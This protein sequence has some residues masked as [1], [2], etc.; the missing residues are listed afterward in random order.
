MAFSR[1][2]MVAA[3]A[4]SI[5]LALL[6]GCPTPPPT[7]SPS[8]NPSV[9]P[10]GTTSTAPS[11]T[12][13]SSTAPST[14]PSDSA[15]PSTTPSASNL[16]PTTVRGSVFDEDGARVNTA[17]VRVRS[18]NPSNPFDSTVDVN[19]GNYV[20][21][22]VPA[23]VAVELTVSREGWTSR[24]RVQTLLPLENNT[25]DSNL[26][27]FGGPA[28]DKD[29]EG[30]A[31]F[32]SD[33]P[34]V[35]MVEPADDADNVNAST[36]SV[37]LTLSEALDSTNQRRFADAIRVF[38]GEAAADPNTT[39]A[40]YLSEA[41]QAT[42]IADAAFDDTANTLAVTEDS[43]FLGDDDTQADVTWDT[44]G[45]VATLTFNAPLLS[46]D[47]ENLDYVVALV[48]GAN[49]VE[50]KSGNELGTDETGVLGT[51]NGTGRLIHFA[52]REPSLA[53]PSGSNTPGDD[54]TRWRLTHEN[55]STFSVAEDETEPSLVSVAVSQLTGRTRIS[56]T[57]SEPMAAYGGGDLGIYGNLN[58]AGTPSVNNTNLGGGDVADFQTR[59][60][61]AVAETAADLEDVDLDGEGATAQALNVIGDTDGEQETELAFNFGTPGTATASLAVNPDDPKTLRLEIAK[62]NLF[63]ADMNAIKVR[64]EGI[65]DPAGNTIT[66][67]QADRNQKVGNI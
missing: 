10:S 3:V 16:K 54:D 36:V 27:N 23:G 51:S 56:L 11:T 65:S 19:G 24:T 29:G 45:T 35:S 49:A 40:T 18:L 31:Y 50:D 43:T 55:F 64:V 32:I 52:F 5:S 7:V 47:N 62:A 30:P 60:T 33:F 25:S 8:G 12:P 38:P 53:V 57:F 6:T 15:S 44:T 58:A 4:G 28:S 67:S 21:N 61:F 22:E 39:N 63:D 34:E 9:Q 13:T 59:L 42:F 20:V 48:A 37:K 66:E 17:K 41:Q 46:D 1:N 26:V 14:N 2:S